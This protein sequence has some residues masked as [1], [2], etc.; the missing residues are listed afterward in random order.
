MKPFNL[1]EALAGKQVVTRDGRPVRIAGYNLEA[2]D[3]FRLAAWID[4]EALGWHEDGVF[5]RRS[6]SVYDLFMTSKE[7]WVVL[8]EKGGMIQTFATETFEEAKSYESGLSLRGYKTFGVHKI[9]I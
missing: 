1:E 5:F 7:V 2:V 4:G 8:Y 3:G 6:E 9:E